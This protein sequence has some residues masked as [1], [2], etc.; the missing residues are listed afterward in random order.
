MPNTS[1]TCVG[2]VREKGQVETE[3]ESEPETSLNH[4]VAILSQRMG[5]IH[6]HHTV[7]NKRANDK[8]KGI[9][10]STQKMTD[11]IC[12]ILHQSD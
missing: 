10:E 2:I 11:Q 8:I 7:A 9:T 1:E 3:S 5:M 12:K 6:A 4:E